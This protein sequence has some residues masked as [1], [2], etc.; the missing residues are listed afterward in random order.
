M[1]ML[2]WL[3]LP[4]TGP[5]RGIM[6]IAQHAAE[7]AEREIYDPA[8]VQ[9]QLQELEM[10]FDMGEITDEEY[11]EAEEVLL[12]RLRDIREHLAEGQQQK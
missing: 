7:Q 3:A 9:G 10:R 1:G 12:G 4:V 8:A 11:A 5:I 6:W 2:E